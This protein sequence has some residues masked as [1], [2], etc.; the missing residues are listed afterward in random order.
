MP[1]GLRPVTL[2]VVVGAATSLVP[3]AGRAGAQRRRV[4]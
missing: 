2:Q 1:N 4:V 3:N